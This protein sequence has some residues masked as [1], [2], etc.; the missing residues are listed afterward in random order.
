MVIATPNNSKIKIQISFILEHYAQ[1]LSVKCEMRIGCAPVVQSKINPKK[2]VCI[3]VVRRVDWVK[4]RQR[5]Q[6]YSVFSITIHTPHRTRRTSKWQGFATPQIL[7]RSKANMIRYK[8][9]TIRIATTTSSSTKLRPDLWKAAI[10]WNLIVDY[11]VE[12][13]L[14]LSIKHKETASRF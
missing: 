9:F 13:S 11:L 12:N 3:C 5:R 1:E 14:W 4:K 10:K 8:A 2:R 6:V 7:T